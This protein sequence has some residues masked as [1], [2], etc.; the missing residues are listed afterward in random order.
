MNNHIRITLESGL[1]A[2]IKGQKCKYLLCI[3]SQIKVRKAW[4]GV[5]LNHCYVPIINQTISIMVEISFFMNCYIITWKSALLYMPRV[6]TGNPWTLSKHRITH[7][8]EHQY[9][10]DKVIYFYLGR[11]K[12]MKTHV[13]SPRP[14]A[15][16]LNPCSITH[17][18]GHTAA[19]GWSW[20]WQPGGHTAPAAGRGPAPPWWGSASYPLSPGP[21]SGRIWTTRR[22]L[23]AQALTWHLRSEW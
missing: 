16:P 1:L 3:M 21:A 14:K 9:I 11:G 5:S 18:S 20:A 19:P 12:M 13:F 4:V 23:G 17:T 8:T 6:Y 15:V 10:D 22:V 7:K 2:D